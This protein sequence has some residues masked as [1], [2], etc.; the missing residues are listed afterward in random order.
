MKQWVYLNNDFL[1]AEQACIHVS[2][3]A[4][5]RGYGIFD[6]IKVLQTTPIFLDDHLDR[7]FRSAS[8][9]HLPIPQK[10]EA[11]KEIVQ[12]LAV[13]NKL[14]VSGIRL[15]LTGGYSADGYSISTPNLVITQSNFSEPT[16]EARKKGLYLI[17]KNHQRQLAH[18]KT[19]DYLMPIWLQNEVKEKGADDVLYKTNDT[20]T[21]CPRANIFIV[22]KEGVLVTPLKNILQGITRNKILQLAKS[23][24]AVE[25]REVTIQDLSEASEIFITSTTKGVL[26]VRQVDEF[27]YDMQNTVSNYL[28]TQ[29]QIIHNGLSTAETV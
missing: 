15:T 22:T 20:I 14:T 2:D 7:F 23:F 25:E 10:R 26:P 3:L 16:E 4:I 8:A 6:Y 19:I 21:E 27:K 11:L 1:P 17:T 18:V 12:A 29:L 28:I 24:C 5:Q 9:M 13:R